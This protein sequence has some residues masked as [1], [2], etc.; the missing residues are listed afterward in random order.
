MVT[1]TPDIIGR[2]IDKAQVNNRLKFIAAVAAAGYLFDSFDISILSFAMPKIKAELGLTPQQIGLLGSAGL[3]GMGIGSWIWGWIADRLGRRLV[4]AGT[5]LMFSVCTGLT[6]LSFSLGLMIGARFLTGLGLGGMVPID[7][8]LVAEFSPASLRGRL[9]ACLPLFWPLGYFTASGVALLIVPDIGWRWLF[10]I[11][12]VPALLSFVIRKK[13]PE[14]PRWLADQGRHEEAR[15]SLHY[16]GIT[17]AAIETAEREVAALPRREAEPTPKIGDLLTAQYARRMVQTWTMWFFSNFAANAFAVW[18]PTIYA[19]YYH[20]EITR[21]LTY[22]FIIAGSQVVGRIVGYALIDRLGRKPI[23]CGGYFIAGCAALM[24]TRATDET[25][26]LYTAMCYG[27]FADMASLAMT[28]YTPEV[29]PVRI[30]GIATSMAMGI[31]RF[32]GV[33]APLIIGAIIS[34]T[35]I[36]YVWLL[37]ACAQFLASGLSLLMA[38]ETTGQNLEIAGARA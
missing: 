11:G 7:A 19:V 15:E 32:G 6:G 8:A 13:I 30:R 4:F 1:L 10:A 9:V 34:P 26:M 22:S 29:W 24:L 16:I 31:G 3:A 2:A 36:F 21:T 38:R 25:S 20:I 5:V 27:F 33:A 12:V 37:M 18:L 28:V 23:F 35:T 17:D 14:S